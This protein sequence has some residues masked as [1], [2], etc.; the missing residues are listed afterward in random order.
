MDHLEGRVIFDHLDT[1]ARAALETE[2][3]SLKI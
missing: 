3:E 1:D 2:Y